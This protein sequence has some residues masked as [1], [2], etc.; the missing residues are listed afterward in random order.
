MSGGGIASSPRTSSSTRGLVL[1]RAGRAPRTGRACPSRARRGRSQSRRTASPSARRSAGVNA[2]EVDAVVDRA[3][4]RRGGLAGTGPQ[5]GR[6]DE[7]AAAD[8]PRRPSGQP[9]AQQPR[10]QARWSSGRRC[11]A[12][13]AASRAARSCTGR[14]RAA[15]TL[16]RWTTSGGSRRAAPAGAIAA[17]Y[18]ALV[19][20]RGAE[21]RPACAGRRRSARREQ[22]A[23]SRKSPRASTTV[24]Y[25]TPS[26]RC[27]GLLTRVQTRPD[28]RPRAV[29]RAAARPPASRSRST[30]TAGCASCP[31]LRQVRDPHLDGFELRVHAEARARCRSRRGRPGSSPRPGRVARPAASRARRLRRPSRRGTCPACAG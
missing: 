14:D 8:E 17:W 15:R 5:A 9:P 16:C 24:R 28:P 23:A 4:A 20:R 10:R 3:H 11:G 21:Q 25:S 7:L 2:L 26:S 27:I 13:S 18:D 30:R 12:R 31:G 22:P 1:E 29:R 19:R 6:V